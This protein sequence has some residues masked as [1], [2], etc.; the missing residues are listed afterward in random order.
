MD[1]LELHSVI[2]STISEQY[3]NVTNANVKHKLVQFSAEQISSL[4]RSPEVYIIARNGYH[5]GE[6]ALCRSLRFEHTTHEIYV[7]IITCVPKLRGKVKV[8]GGMHAFHNEVAR[9]C[10]A[11]VYTI[12]YV[13]GTIVN[14]AENDQ[15]LQF[16]FYDG[17]KLLFD[18]DPLRPQVDANRK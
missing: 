15:L 7:A 10:C 9:R 3:A 17:A 4:L 1:E 18:P 2:V 5:R 16:K 14:I 11:R 8:T 12:K 6:D 13:A